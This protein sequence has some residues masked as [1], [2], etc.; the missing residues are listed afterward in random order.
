MPRAKYADVSRKRGRHLLDRED[1]VLVDL[2]RQV[3]VPTEVC[4]LM[5]ILT[6]PLEV[7]APEQLLLFCIVMNIACDGGGGGGGGGA[8]WHSQ[9]NE[10]LLRLQVVRC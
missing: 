9:R 3:I 6:V 4:E 8:V 1:E 5:P 7:L 2:G 10:S